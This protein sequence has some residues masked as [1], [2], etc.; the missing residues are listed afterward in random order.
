MKFDLKCK[1]HPTYQGKT[2]PSDCYVCVTLYWLKAAGYRL[3]DDESVLKDKTP[4][5]KR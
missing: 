5:R 4:R 1:K 3:M 2:W